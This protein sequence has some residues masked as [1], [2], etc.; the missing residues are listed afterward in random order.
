MKEIF[1]TYRAFAALKEDGTVVTWGNHEYGGDSS[2]VTGLT[3]VKEIFSQRLCVS[4]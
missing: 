4:T 3:N 2:G 1:S